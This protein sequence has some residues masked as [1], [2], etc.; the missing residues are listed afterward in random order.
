M[1]NIEK[2]I[3]EEMIEKARKDK[4]LSLESIEYEID[5]TKKHKNS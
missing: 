5:R 3:I 4:V 2:D 1:E